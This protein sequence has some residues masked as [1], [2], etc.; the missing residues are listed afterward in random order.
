[1]PDRSAP[2]RL[3]VLV[4][5]AVLVV[6][7]ALPAAATPPPAPHP[8]WVRVNQTGRIAPPAAAGTLLAYDSAANR[9]VLFGGWNGLLLDQTWVFD[10]TN[11]SWSELHPSV[12]PAARADAAFV[13][14]ASWGRFV[15]FGG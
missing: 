3:A 2:R 12:A 13:Y 4:A 1:M 8:S 10:P 5:V 9:F 11:T 7:P 6:V 15:L 14:D